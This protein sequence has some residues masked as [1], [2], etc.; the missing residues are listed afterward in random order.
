[1]NPEFRKMKEDLES[2]V[3]RIETLE[4]R[5]NGLENAQLKADVRHEDVVAALWEDEEVADYRLG[6]KVTF[7]GRSLLAIGGGLLIRTIGVAEGSF[8][9][10]SIGVGMLYACFWTGMAFRAGSRSG[11]TSSTFHGV[12]GSFIGFPL[13]WEATSKL[14][15]WPAFVAVTILVLFAALNLFLAFRNRLP[16]VG[17]IATAGATATTLVLG[18]T[19]PHAILYA[20]GMVNLSL[21]TLWLGYGGR[22]FGPAV[23]TA[24]AI[25]IQ[26]VVFALMVN[27]SDSLHLLG[28]FVPSGIIYLQIVLLVCYFSSFADR[29]LRQHREVTVAEIFIGSV[30]VCSLAF[31]AIPL[32]GADSGLI[33][34]LGILSFALGTSCYGVT[35]ALIEKSRA[36]RKTRIFYTTVAIFLVI[37]GFDL[38]LSGS[39]RIWALALVAFLS[40]WSGSWRN[41]VTLALHSS[42]YVI[43]AAGESG[44]LRGALSTIFQDDL[45]TALWRTSLP[46]L[47]LVLSVVCPLFPV[48]THGRTWGRLAHAPKILWAVTASAC[49]IGFG[50]ILLS[51]SY[52]RLFGMASSTATMSA[53]RTIVLVA[54]TMIL[55]WVGASPRYREARWLV[56]PIMLLAGC[57]LLLEDIPRGTTLSKCVSF[58]AYGGALFLVPSIMK[59]T[60]HAPVSPEHEEVEDPKSNA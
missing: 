28:P 21:M 15:A 49:V 37:V 52:E 23:F 16:L 56:I 38:T 39:E 36:A 45:D 55:V 26:F 17:W 12:V 13:I 19:E 14:H 42:I 25:N 3:E 4:C 50:I 31:V 24:T 60:A 51:W 6:E 18:F 29:T 54:V 57:K 53:I 47:I 5:L 35:F 34:T 41:R 46:Y 9:R 30:S 11:K 1:M 32:A 7:F 10:L 58:V 8:L 33:N 40:A 48:A 22:G 43:V 2:L 59:R 44:V 20:G 27:H